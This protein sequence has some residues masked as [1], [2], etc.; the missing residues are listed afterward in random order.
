MRSPKYLSNEESGTMDHRVEMCATRWHGNN[1]VNYL[2]T[3]HICELTDSVRRRSASEKKHIQV[4]R[5][6]IIKAH[7]VSS[8]QSPIK[9][10]S[11]VNLHSTI[12]RAAPTRIPV[13]SV[14]QDGCN[15]G[16]TQ[17]NKGRCRYTD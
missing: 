9:L 6:A 1:I 2:Y 3:L 10:P 15:D 14:R 16:P 7:H 4:N 11:N 5:P 8:S 13:D 12:P 17:T